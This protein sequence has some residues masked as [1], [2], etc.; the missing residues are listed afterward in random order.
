MLLSVL[1][2]KVEFREGG[3]HYDY[4]EVVLLNEQPIKVLGKFS[5][6][7]DADNFRLGFLKGIEY[8]EST[9]ETI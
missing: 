6:R 7:F 2:E 9:K 5:T 8:Y 4:Y 1:V 3:T